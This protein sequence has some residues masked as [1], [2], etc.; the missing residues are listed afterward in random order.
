MCLSAFTHLFSYYFLSPSLPFYWSLHLFYYILL[1]LQHWWAKSMHNAHPTPQ[2]ECKWKP[3]SFSMSHIYL[4]EQ[5]WCVGE[6]TPRTRCS[7]GPQT[8]ISQHST[9]NGSSAKPQVPT[10]ANHNSYKWGLFYTGHV[11]LNLAE[12]RG[13]RKNL[14]SWE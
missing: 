1:F 10:T 14:L 13:N 4:G 5:C 11:G 12:I 3:G 6:C 2:K 8:P 9:G 7:A